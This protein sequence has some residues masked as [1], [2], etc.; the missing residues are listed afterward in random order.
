MSELEHTKLF[1]CEYKSAAEPG[2]F[3]AYVST[4]GNKDRQDD[5]VERGAFAD[6]LKETGGSVPILMGHITSRIVGFGISAEENE[7]GLK[8]LGEF[9]LESDEGRNAYAIAQHAAKLGHKL[10]LSIG[11]RV[12][13]DGA[14][15]DEARGVRRLK[16]VDLYEYSIAAVPANPRATMTRVKADGSGDVDLTVSEVERVLR[17]AGFSRVE[18]KRLISSIRA[19]RDAE[20]PADPDDLAVTKSFAGLLAEARMIDLTAHAREIFAPWKS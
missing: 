9:T 11:Y 6:T 14:E 19:L 10:G 2:Q 1:D 15:F 5:I 17:D 8:V 18:A 4:F 16:S 12:R 3:E 20:S 7:R 13:K